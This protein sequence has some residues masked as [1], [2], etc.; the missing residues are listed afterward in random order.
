M[1]QLKRT[2]TVNSTFTHNV[3]Y[4]AE[5]TVLPYITINILSFAHIQNIQNCADFEQNV[6]S[7]TVLL[8]WLSF[9]KNLTGFTL[10][11]ILHQREKLQHLSEAVSDK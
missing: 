11:Q 8:P 9:I 10:I 1:R 5:S 7:L 3:V 4:V 2:K 6:T